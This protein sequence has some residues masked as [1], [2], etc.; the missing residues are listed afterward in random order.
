MP[1]LSLTEVEKRIQAL[2]EGEE[3]TVK[4]NYGEK[5]TVRKNNQKQRNNYPGDYHA[6]KPDH[7]DCS[8]HTYSGDLDGLMAL[9]AQLRKRK[10]KKA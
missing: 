6:W 5:I 3:M 4:C 10:P 9:I 7:K 2:N 8:L 1:K